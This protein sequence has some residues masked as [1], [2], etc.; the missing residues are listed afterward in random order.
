MT[1]A[2]L[3]RNLACLVS[4]DPN[5][6]VYRDV[7]LLCEDGVVRS[8]TPHDPEFQYTDAEVID[9]RDLLVY[10][11]L[12]NTHHH[13][14]QALVRNQLAL[15]WSR[16]SL[17][18]WL[19]RIY[20]IF[21]LI[22]EDC[23]YHASLVSLAELAK[24]GCT[25]AFDHQ[26]CFNRH[27]GT[28]LIDRQFDAAAQVGLRLVAGRGTNTLPR[29]QGS[30]MP[31]EMLETT[32]VFL[33]DCERLIKR[34]H[35]AAPH[36]MTNVVVAPCQPVNCLEDTFIEGMA[37]AR[38]HGVRLHT[39]L[40]EGENEL[41]QARWG[42]RSLDWCLEREIAGGDVWFAHCW[43]MSEDEL[44]RMGETSTG[45]SH[46]PAAMC[47]VGD[48]IT[49]LA[50]AHAFGVPIGL[51]VDGQASND[52]SN[53]MECIRLAYLLQCL[54]A[55]SRNYPLPEA[56]RFLNFATTGGAQLLGRSEL[57]QLAPGSA[58]DFFAVDR[59]GVDFAAT[60][61]DPALLPVKT[62]ISG[63]V[64]LTVVA[65]RV[66]WRDGAFSHI[67][68]EAV[69]MAANRVYNDVIFK[70]PVLSTTGVSPT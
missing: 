23:I 20:Q 13:F 52:N 7:D 25:T 6:S 16:L 28:Q 40:S 41:M 31:D 57:G 15:D 38:S 39:H 68:E 62:G 14:F 69:T 43:E 26:Y 5:S 54:G 24:H 1:D 44:R 48:G 55:S 21:T 64:D 70:S 46:C 19:E 9:G 56:H 36:A 51:G 58:A 53:L 8:I 42:Q 11:G 4:C 67:D 30:T 63:A 37:L 66:V 18:Q 33:K 27:A 2:L 12:V 60:L 3:V 32:E 10:P 65:G 59:R 49:D 35:D 34:Y 29:S 45:L 61:H 50:A 17:V 22:N 47:L